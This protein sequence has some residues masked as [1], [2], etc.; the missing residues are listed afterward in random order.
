VHNIG[1][2]LGEQIVTRTSD[3]GDDR[4]NLDDNFGDPL[5]F[6]GS[7]AVAFSYFESRILAFNET[8][9]RWAGLSSPVTDDFQTI[10]ENIVL[11]HPY[12]IFGSPNSG[13]S[14]AAYVF[15]RVGTTWTQ[16]AT[17]NSTEVGNGGGFA[18]KVAISRNLAL[19]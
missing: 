17:L 7:S 18:T 16:I 19:A 10:G 6:S 8:S 11:D 15:E 2:F 14:G 1:T 12:F 9:Q 3:D 4:S 5:F 13:T